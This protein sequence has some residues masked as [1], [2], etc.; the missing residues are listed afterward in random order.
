[1]V[2]AKRAYLQQSG[3]A[4]KKIRFS[5]RDYTRAGLPIGHRTSL[6][7]L[8]TGEG[9]H[10]AGV[11]PK[12]PLIRLPDSGIPAIHYRYF[13]R[14]MYL[15][16]QRRPFKVLTNNWPHTQETP[17]NAVIRGCSG[18]QSPACTGLLCRSHKSRTQS[19]QIAACAHSP[20]FA[21]RDSLLAC[22]C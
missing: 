21:I 2:F 17:A 6:G 11:H 15:P 1:M 5:R 19:H 18:G 4:S 20:P 7:R 8:S 9:L 10:T 14:S 3:R 16:Q 22:S 12:L 13:R